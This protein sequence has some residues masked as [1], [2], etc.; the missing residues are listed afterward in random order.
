MRATGATAAIVVAGGSG[1]VSRN[2]AAV[3]SEFSAGD[4]AVET[5]DGTVSE[6]YIEPTGGVTWGDFDVPVERIAVTVDWGVDDDGSATLSDAETDGTVS[7][8]LD[9]AAAGTSGDRSWDDLGRITLYDGAD[10]R[11]TFDALRD[12]NAK[13]TVVVLELT[14]ELLD[15]EGNLADPAEQ[16]RFTLGDTFEATVTNRAASAHGSGR[17]NTGIN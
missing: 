1:I 11:T 4:V 3:Q 2:A 8:T 16:A 10:G 14:V 5:H 17:A 15:G 7:T 12:G 13:T 9:V 6:V